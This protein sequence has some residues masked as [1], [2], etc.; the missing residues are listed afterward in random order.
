MDC[1]NEDVGI[2]KLPRDLVEYVILDEKDIELPTKEIYIKTWNTKQAIGIA[3]LVH[4]IYI[5]MPVII[6]H[7]ITINRA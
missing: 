7:N 4:Y 5:C 2:W 6:E 1:G 3:I